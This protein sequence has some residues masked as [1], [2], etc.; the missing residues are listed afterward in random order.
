MSWHV[1]LERLGL[2]VVVLVC[3]VYFEGLGR[4]LI[5]EDLNGFICKLNVGTPAR[6]ALRWA[7]GLGLGGMVGSAVLGAFYLFHCQ[8]S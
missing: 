2:A 4:C 1:R 7:C 8:I 6:A 3:T 5:C